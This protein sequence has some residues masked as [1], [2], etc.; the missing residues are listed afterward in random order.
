MGV[1]REC[2]C[3]YCVL[4]EEERRWRHCVILKLIFLFSPHLSKSPTVR[5]QK[6]RQLQIEAIM[7]LPPTGISVL[8][9]WIPS[10]LIMSSL[11]PFIRTHTWE[12]HTWE[13]RSNLR[14]CSNVQVRL[15][16]GRKG[17][18]GSMLTSWRWSR[19]YI[20]SPHSITLDY[21]LIRLKFKGL[22]EC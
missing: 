10:S 5:D 3:I 13:G 11:S 9:Q 19:D 12:G 15:G 6:K 1:L 21:S 17:N 2:A 4:L 22:M 18:F 14:C 20:F 16:L 7:F 8:G